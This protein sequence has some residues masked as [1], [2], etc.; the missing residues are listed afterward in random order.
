MAVHLEHLDADVVALGELVGNA[1]DAL[2]GDLR[3]VHEPVPAGE[4][5]HEGAEVHELNHPALVDLADLDVRRQKLNA[6]ARLFTRRLVHGGDGDGAVIADIDVGAGLLGELADGRA[7]LAD[8]VPDLLRIDLEGD[9]P[10]RVLGHLLARLADHI[11]HVLEHAEP[12][13]A[14]LLQGPLHDLAGNP[15]DLDVHLQGGHAVLG[16]GHL[17]VHV[18]EVV[19]VAKD[20]REDGEVIA[21]LDQA[22]GDAGHGGLQR[23]AGIHEREAGTADRRHGAGAIGLGDLRDHADDVGAVLV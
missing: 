8:D 5:V 9:Q 4:D 19:L 12:A 18:T 14:R 11:V 6:P 20:I 13:L 17:E 10:R 21:L 15:V 23:Y 2:I 16:A 1:L 3:D 7:A 22:H